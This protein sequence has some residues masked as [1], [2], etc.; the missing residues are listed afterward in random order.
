MPLRRR[1]LYTFLTLFAGLLLFLAGTHVNK[2]PPQLPP[3]VSPDSYPDTPET[4]AAYAAGERAADR[5]HE[6][7][8]PVKAPLMPWAED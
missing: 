1:L 7:H 8:A 6:I 3:V 2:P 4:R 5:F